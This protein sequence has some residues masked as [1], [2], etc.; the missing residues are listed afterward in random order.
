MTD[1]LDAEELDAAIR[2]VR[3]RMVDGIFGLVAE[4][5]L[6]LKAAE[7]TAATL[8][9]W[10]EIEVECW[11]IVNLDGGLAQVYQTERAA[12]NYFRDGGTTGDR[13]VRLTGTTKVPA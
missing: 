6:I 3:A 9:R 10:K 7:I 1:I 5:N 8:P 11:V 12:Q 2:R 4:T 13:I